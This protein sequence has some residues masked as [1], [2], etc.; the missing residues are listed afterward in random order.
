[1]INVYVIGVFDLFHTGHV[2]LLRRSKNL[3]D[4]LIVAVNGD[5][6]VSDYKRKPYMPELD[7][8]KIV[9]ACRYVDDAFVVEGFDNKELL[10]K[11]KI[12]K[13]VHGDDWDRE[14]YLKQIRVDECFLEEHNIEMVFLPYTEGIS[15]GELI[16]K[17]KDN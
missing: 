9:K 14:S 16:K 8:L 3:G 2:E 17:I 7:R 10:K 15:T 4:R 13:I 1:M 11:H 6:M 5:A 12:S